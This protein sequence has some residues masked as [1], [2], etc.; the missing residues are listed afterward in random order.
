MV[1]SDTNIILPFKTTEEQ[2]AQT[3][4]QYFLHCFDCEP[5]TTTLWVA[6]KVLLYQL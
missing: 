1:S 5:L 3:T 6:F 4:T 2:N